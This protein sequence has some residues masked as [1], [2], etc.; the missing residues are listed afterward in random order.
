VDVFPSLQKMIA[1]A[2]LFVRDQH[3]AVM[4]LETS[5][6]KNWEIPGGGMEPGE[7]PRECAVR[8]A[9]EELGI[10]LSAG[11][12][13]LT[14][15]SPLR[16]EVPVPHCHFIFDAQ[17]PAGLD[18]STIRLG[19]NEIKAYRFMTPS[20]A[21]GLCGPRL[22]PKVLLCAEAII[23]GETIYVDDTDDI[24]WPD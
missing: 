13:L 3:G 15:Y 16:A 21:A 24:D 22:G 19:P 11:R 4:V 7:T 20:E 23:T 12:L 2:G 9:L 1:A 14:S 10:S 17:V 5:Y 8:E 6:K 18:P